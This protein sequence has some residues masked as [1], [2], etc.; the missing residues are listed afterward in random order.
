MELKVNIKTK[1]LDKTIEHIPAEE[2]ALWKEIGK[3]LIEIPRNSIPN[4]M[5]VIVSAQ[6]SD[7]EYLKANYHIGKRG[8]YTLNGVR[9]PSMYVTEEMYLELY[10]PGYVAKS[11]YP[12]KMLTCV[13]PESNNYKYYELLPI[14]NGFGGY[15]THI[16]ARYGRI[17]ADSGERFGEKTLS[18]PYPSYMYWIRY[19]EKLSKGYVD[20]FSEV[21]G[22]K[23][24]ATKADVKGVEEKEV[25]VPKK[26]KKTSCSAADKELYS[27][28]KSVTR[29]YLDNVLINHKSVTK[30]QLKTAGKLME[31]LRNASTVE[32]V[33]DIIK[34]LMVL[35]PRRTTYV[36]D[37][38][39]DSDSDIP[40][41][42]EREE[43]LFNALEAEACGNTQRDTEEAE[44]FGDFDI[45]VKEPTALQDK[46]IRSL[47][48]GDMQGSIEKIYSVIPHKQKRI[49]QE[50]VE[51]NNITKTDLFLHGSRNEN[52]LSIALNSLSLHPDAV[53]T[54]KGLGNGLYFGNHSRKCSHYTGSDGKMI[55]GVFRCAYGEPKRIYDTGYYGYTPHTKAE[56]D[57]EHKNCIHY[58]RQNVNWADEIV[59]YDER[60]VLLQA[61]VVLK[62]R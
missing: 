3:T 5:N 22:D 51:K 18:H 41:I 16:S 27:Y 62:R 24:L 11:V 32:D 28:L 15:T 1:E 36:K 35:M 49:F 9:Y 44:G 21:L 14:D 40:E 46:R 4:F 54:G 39:A 26:R 23:E 33:N 55:I 37:A 10:S 60:A 30:S 59:F 29:Q 53:I 31:E 50:Y 58:H 19:Y 52:W 38:L 47:F 20:T 34:K 12:S 48:S 13:N 57:R 42:V 7:M 2:S 61:I 8:S 25:S 43:D 6:A 45:V 17:G 56:L